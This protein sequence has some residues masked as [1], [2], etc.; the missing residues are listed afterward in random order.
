MSNTQNDEAIFDGLN[1][2]HDGITFEKQ[3]NPRYFKFKKHNLPEGGSPLMP[4]LVMRRVAIRRADSST[5]T[6][7]IPDLVRDRVMAVNGGAPLAPTLCALVEWAL[8]E[9]ERTNKI[10]EISLAD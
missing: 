2:D 5:H 8:N 6:M 10:L 9:L 4:R 7:F 3:L 1:N